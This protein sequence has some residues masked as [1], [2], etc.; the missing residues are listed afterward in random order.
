[1]L[2]IIIIVLSLT[3]SQRVNKFSSCHPL[4]R[5]IIKELSLDIIGLLH[6]PFYFNLGATLAVDGVT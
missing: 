6:V 5:C 2:E 1:M 3:A 4:S